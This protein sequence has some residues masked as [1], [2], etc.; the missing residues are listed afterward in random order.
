MITR[1]IQVLTHLIL[2]ILP[3]TGDLFSDNHA[4]YYYCSDSCGFCHSC[5]A[6]QISSTFPEIAGSF[7]SSASLPTL[8]YPRKLQYFSSS[9]CVYDV[10]YILLIS[11]NTRDTIPQTSAIPLSTKSFKRGLHLHRAQLIQERFYIG[12]RNLFSL[13]EDYLGINSGTDGSLT[14]FTIESIQI[15]CCESLEFHERLVEVDR[16][17][18]G[19]IPYLCNSLDVVVML[20]Q[21]VVEPIGLIAM[22]LV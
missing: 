13:R 18:H 3:R 11:G 16:A 5:S 15:G 19:L 2:Q 7:L 22:P 20:A 9:C 12:E 8:G 21:I 6:Y 4:R 17:S 14:N 1:L 10:C